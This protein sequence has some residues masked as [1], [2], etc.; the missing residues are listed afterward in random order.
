MLEVECVL[1]SIINLSR[2]SNDENKLTGRTVTFG[3]QNS[4]GE[5]VQRVMMPHRDGLHTIQCYLFQAM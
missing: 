3:K 1:R 5:R 4:R 2:V